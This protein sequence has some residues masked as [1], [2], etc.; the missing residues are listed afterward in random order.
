[1]WRKIGKAI[2]VMIGWCVV[3]AYL[4]FASHLTQ[5][6]RANQKVK[7][8]VVSLPDSS[9]TQRFTSSARVLKLVESK[10]I[11]MRGVQIDNLNTVE[12]V[13]AIAEEGY[14]RDADAYVTSNG[15][16]C[17][18]V[19]Q[20]KPVVRLLCGGHNSYIT[21]EGYIFRA[22]RGSSCYA[23][24]VT[25][26]YRPQF[27]RDYKGEVSG[28]YAPSLK[29]MD[30]TE[31]SMT[32]ELQ[33]LRNEQ[34]RCQEKR[35]ECENEDDKKMYDDKIATLNSREER[36]KAQRPILAERRQTL[37]RRKRDFE[38]LLEFVAYVQ[39][40]SF[41]SAEIVQFIADTTFTGEISLRLVPRSSSCVV[42]FGTL[43]NS[44]D[45]LDKLRGFY[46]K[47]LRYMGWN[48]YK[49]VDIRYDKQ[50]ICT[51]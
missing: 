32:K 34:I 7:E 28:V 16:L 6:S 31:K 18:D 20:H 48:R 3:V 42:E 49:T 47:G 8:V 24:V 22:P 11:K 5:S 46:D 1:M 36:I 12:I 13:N 25:G 10:G 15:K 38:S 35:D 30:E 26:C 40:D 19:Y 9:A 33:L 45:K 21:E 4:V 50:I 44:V 29:E 23:A 43:N 39:N 37:L 41:W 17:I 14:V 2:G 51:E 27:K